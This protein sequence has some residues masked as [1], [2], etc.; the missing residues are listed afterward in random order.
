MHSQQSIKTYNGSFGNCIQQTHIYY[1]FSDLKH[2]KNIWTYDNRI[3]GET[4]YAGL[5][6]MIVGITGLQLQ[7]QPRLTTELMEKY[8]QIIQGYSKGLSGSWGCIF[9]CNPMWFL[10]MG[11]RQGSGLCSSSSWKYPGTEGTNQNRPWNHHRWHAANSLERT[12]L[13]CWCL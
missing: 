10:S 5:F 4:D 3:N 8:K 2:K 7:M 1:L 13:S 12:R 6:E 11:L 9:R